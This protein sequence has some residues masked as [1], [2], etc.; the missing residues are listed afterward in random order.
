MRHSL[1]EEKERRQTEQSVMPLEDSAGEESRLKLQPPAQKQRAGEENDA[2]TKRG[3]EE[4]EE[5]LDLVEQVIE[6]AL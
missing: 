5:E 6:R 3:K 1:L 2:K 4:A